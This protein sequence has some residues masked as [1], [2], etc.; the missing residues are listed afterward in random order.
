MFYMELYGLFRCWYDGDSYLV[1]DSLI[2]IS[3]NEQGFNKIIEGIA[4]GRT[5]ELFIYPEMPPDDG[6]Y[7]D[8]RL[9]LLV[10]RLTRV[11]EETYKV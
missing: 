3:D 9:R 5:P 4:A 10:K 8:E 7:A 6:R 2:A 11:V 1:T